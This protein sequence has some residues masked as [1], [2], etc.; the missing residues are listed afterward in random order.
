[1]PAKGIISSTPFE[2]EIALIIKDNVDRIRNELSGTRRVL[3]YDLKP[4]PFEIINDTYYDTKDKF[5]REKRITLRIRKIDDTLLISTKSDI[6][7]IAE[8]IIQ[9]RELERPWSYNSIRMIA[10]NLKL[11]TPTVSISNFQRV[12]I[13]R[14]LATMALDVNQQR[15]TERKPRDIVTRGEIPFSVAEMAIDGV[16]YAFED[17]KVGF[18]E[19]EVEAKAPRSLS[20]IREI[21]DALVSKYRPSLQQWFHGKFVTGL[22]IQRLVKTRVLQN[23]L[24]NS[25]LGPDAFELIDRTIR[26]RKF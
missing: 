5:L 21:A 23:Y 20:K 8:N 9:R 14:V 15:R 13:S 24:A 12:P 6:R 2:S 11:K 25:D 3:E 1:M 17:L 26:S 16:T 19:I 18:S 4:K 10:R 22:A 7:K